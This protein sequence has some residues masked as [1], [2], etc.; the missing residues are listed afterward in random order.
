[1]ITIIRTIRKTN[2]NTHTSRQNFTDKDIRE[3][4]TIAGREFNSN[5]NLLHVQVVD[6]SGSALILQK[7]LDGKCVH[8]FSA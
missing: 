4:K 6:T 5:P 1:M 8:R 2:A 3:V 7:D